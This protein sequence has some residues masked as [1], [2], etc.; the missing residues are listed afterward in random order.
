[1]KTTYIQ[2][3]TKV[4]FQYTRL[5]VAAANV[6]KS[7]RLFIIDTILKKMFERLKAGKR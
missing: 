5:K 3:V 4:K 6:W 2:V 1:M 7:K